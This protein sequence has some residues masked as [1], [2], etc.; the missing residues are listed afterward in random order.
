MGGV[1]PKSKDIYQIITARGKDKIII[2]IPKLRYLI[3]E[4]L[5]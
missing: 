2:S 1:I 5:I 3:A 4:E